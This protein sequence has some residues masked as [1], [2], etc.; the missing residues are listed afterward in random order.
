MTPESIAA[1]ADV[2]FQ[3]RRDGCWLAGLPEGLAPSTVDEGYAIQEAFRALWGAHRVS[4]WKVGATA[5]VIMDRFGVSEPFVGPFFDGD[6]VESPA[7]LAAAQHPYLCVE[8][9]FAFRLGRAITPRPAPY[10]RDEMV[11]AIASVMPAW[12]VIGP[13]Y[14]SLMFAQVASAI[15]D[16][17]LNQAMVLGSET[18]DWRRLH[19]SRHPVRFLV[20]GKLK[21]EGSGAA[22]MGDPITAMV[23]TAN[24]FSKR[25]LTLSAGQIISTGATCG[26]QF[27]EPGELAEADFGDLGRISIRFFGP[28]SPVIVQRS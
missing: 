12:E 6:L 11:E 25:G 24:H 23:W 27:L 2:L 5:K 16:C 10:S 7:E 28:R 14:S 4:G 17:G 1:A 3:A 20:D 9:E 15:A 8:A 26:V 18:K 22:V 21:A 19:L 13:R